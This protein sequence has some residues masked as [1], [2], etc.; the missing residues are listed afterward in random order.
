MFCVYLV[1]CD[2]LVGVFWFGFVGFCC[3]F[4]WVFALVDMLL[5]WVG[6]FLMLFWFG[7]IVVVVVWV[8]LCWVGFCVY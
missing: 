7:L 4:V 8:S 5:C 3:E 2:L 6:W 1:V